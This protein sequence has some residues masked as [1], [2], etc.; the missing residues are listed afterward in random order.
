[1]TITTTITARGGILVAHD[2]SPGSDGALRTAIR[3]APAF[4]NHVE[5]VRAWTLATAPAVAF[6]APG[7]APSYEDFE[8][9]VLA[10]LEHDVA[11]LR[12]EEP[13]IA[14]GVTVVH[15]NAAEKLVDA[16]HHVDMIVVADRG[17]GGFVGLLL[18]S[19]TDQVV[20]HSACR[21]LVEREHDDPASSS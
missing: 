11:S 16:S 7:R 10:A 17:H 19:V 21:V 5:V 12:R 6:L 13:E 20:H 9:A 3:C 15:G 18:G 4:G 14:I 8:Q 1:M 2:G